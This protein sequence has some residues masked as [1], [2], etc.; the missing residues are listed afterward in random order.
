ML[1][2]FCGFSFALILLPNSILSQSNHGDCKITLTG[3]VEDLN[4]SEKLEYASIYIA[5][6]QKGIV[7]D[8]NGFF[9]IENLCAGNITL[10]ITHIGCVNT[11]LKV[12]LA[13][14]TIL[15]VFMD[16]KEES[17]AE[18][19]VSEKANYEI[20]QINK[21][22]M[23]SAEIQRLQGLPLGEMLKKM[24][25]VNSIN[26][27]ASISKPVVHGLHS[28][29][30]LILN[31]GIRQEGQQWGT[32]H[33]PEIDPYTT[34]RVQLSEGIDALQ[35]ASDAFG[36]VLIL[37]PEDLP[38][39]PSLNCEL[40]FGGFSNNRQGNGAASIKGMVSKKF[41]L[42]FKI[43]GSTKM[44]GN[45]KTPNYYQSNTG[46]KENNFSIF[47]GIEKGRF[48]TKIYYSQFNQTLGIYANSHIGNLTDLK[49]AILNISRFDTAGFTY[50]IDR[51]YQEIF[52]ELFKS[53]TFWSTSESS[54]IHLVLGRQ[55]D[56]RK[57]FDTHIKI[58][59]SDLDYNLTTHTGDLGWT[60]KFSN[61]ITSLVGI[62]A[63]IRGNTYR[64]TREFIP[65]YKNH[66]GGI[67][68]IETYNTEKVGYKVGMRYD[69][70]N[71]KVYSNNES[72]NKNEYN[73]NDFAGGFG[74]EFFKNKNLQY[75]ANLSTLW[76][77]PA[78]TE[79][80]SQGLHHGAA[81][82]EFGDENLSKER[83]FNFTLGM[84]YKKDKKFELNVKPFLYFIKNYIS[85]DPTEVELTIRGAFPSF[86]Y[87]Q[88]DAVFTGADLETAYNINKQWIVNSQIS[89]LYVR[90]IE[91]KNYF[92]QIP[93]SRINTGIKKLFKE[94]KFLKNM[95]LS[96]SA[97]WTMKQYFAPR[98]LT[99]GDFEN[100][101]QIENYSIFDF[102]PAPNGYLLAALETGFEVKV[103]EQMVGVNLSVE[104]L[105][106]SVYRNY[107]NRFRY[108][109]DEMGRNFSIRIKIPIGLIKV[110]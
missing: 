103:K 110:K 56:N 20:K 81:A 93:P 45:I 6:Q 69:L 11:K 105:F 41:P 57:E 82:L 101:Q 50:N 60:N 3:K 16:H 107:M 22:K 17:L 18:V 30:L 83:I 87:K 75:T 104:N 48:Q 106:N 23:T 12:K 109:A 46:M 15:V 32:E 100:P 70:N 5:E 7:C 55:F 44:G 24:A 4:S 68:L 62:N 39:K 74:L 72:I 42:A 89:F 64:G 54:K 61:G 19:Q 108:Y 28:N 9:K 102:A 84:N 53:E 78:V 47:S 10:N 76:R 77:A 52:H 86:N 36:G 96:A 59:N 91:R 80:F 98:G 2:L 65:N 40:L 71:T 99:E 14:D 85:L 67:Y 35:Y 13:V 58:N 49:N 21:T 37:L 95:Y 92:T 94:T 34:D 90:N 29:R 25:G 1:K 66:S 51:P 33:A 8:E 79:L 26:T 31:N 38:L 43:M 97:N 73:F 27:G 63:M 88:S